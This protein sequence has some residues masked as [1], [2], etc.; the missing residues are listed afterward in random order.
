MRI[1]GVDPGYHRTGL[2]VIELAGNKITLVDS[3]LIETSPSEE[4]AVRLLQIY[5]ELENEIILFNPVSVAVEELFFAKNVKTA[6]SVAHARGV[7]LLAAAKNGLTIS[8]YKPAVIKLALTSNGN[9]TKSQ[10]LFMVERLLDR[11]FEKRC[12]DEIDAIA[13]AICH[14]FKFRISKGE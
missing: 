4:L 6:I 10:V 7:V 9:A 8:E 1:L 14:A 3:R 2:A 5:N 11:K 12:D 13:A